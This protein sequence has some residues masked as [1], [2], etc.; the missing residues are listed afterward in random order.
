M[1]ERPDR[2]GLLVTLI[3]GSF[4]LV[5][6]LIVKGSKNKEKMEH[7]SIAVA[8]GALIAILAFDLIPEV[9]SE[10]SFSTFLIPLA[11]TAAGIL[12]LKIVDIFVPEEHNHSK[13]TETEE[14]REHIGFIA[15]IAIILHNI[16]EGMTVYTVAMASASM[17]LSLSIGVGLHN[18]P[19]GM[20]IYSTLER[21]NK[22][23]R[24]VIMALST[25]STFFGGIIMMTLEGIITE[26][27]VG[28]LLCITIGMVLY[29]LLLE[30]LP[31][32]I[33]YPDRKS[34]VIYSVIGLALV[35]LCSFLE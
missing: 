4:F 13:D 12:L 21:D 28:I 33:H 32:V 27:L 6:A 14:N 2:M 35:F 29:I 17:G 15:A 25:L 8:F 30:L 3:L 22:A 23:R 11:S 24:Y 18:I 5:G 19:M 26:L 34:T 31:P 7:I 16:L 9:I 20:L 10:Y 1:S